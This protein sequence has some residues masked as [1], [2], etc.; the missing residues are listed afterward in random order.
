MWFADSAF[1]SKIINN[2]TF[3]GKYI[4]ND[5]GKLVKDGE[6]VAKDPDGRVDFIINFRNDQYHG[7]MIAFYAG[8]DE[9]ASITNWKNGQKQGKYIWY[10]MG[11]KLTESEYK[12]GIEIGPRIISLYDDANRLEKY[13]TITFE[14]NI[15][16]QPYSTFNP[17]DELIREDYFGSRGIPFC[18]VYYKNNTM[19]RLE[20]FSEF[21]DKKY[22]KD[23]ESSL[24]QGRTVFYFD[25]QQNM[26]MREKY[27]TENKLIEDKKYDPPEKF[28]LQQFIKDNVEVFD[29]SR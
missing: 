19:S 3:R 4:K 13:T 20:Y 11:N 16:Q 7:E 27:S 28:N 12:N 29:D 2:R 6:W 21:I 17:N 10:F 23:I 14:N 5:N 8:T 18:E 9:V 25:S 1:R 22:Q 15:Q 24:S 26:I